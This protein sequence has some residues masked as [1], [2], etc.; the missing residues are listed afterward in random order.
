MPL[1][2][3]MEAYWRVKKWSID[4]SVVFNDGQSS[5]GASGILDVSSR[6]SEANL[7]C[8]GIVFQQLFPADEMLDAFLSVND[9]GIF[10]DGFSFDDILLFWPDERLSNIPV[11]L[12]IG[13]FEIST[14]GSI[15]GAFGIVSAFGLVQAVEWWPYEDA[16]GNALYDTATGQP[17]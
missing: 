10:F 7:V 11:N 9:T 4:I 2:K 17:L 6:G 14:H 16:S 1:V 3:R 8:P 15:F 12:K 5:T 13:N